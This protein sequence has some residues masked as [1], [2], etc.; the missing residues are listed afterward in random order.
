MASYIDYLSAQIDDEDRSEIIDGVRNEQLEDMLTILYAM[1]DYVIMT[2]N[3]RQTG[4]LDS[5]ELR[6]VIR[7]LYALTDRFIDIRTCCYMVVQCL[8]NLEQV[9]PQ[10]QPVIQ[11]LC[12]PGAKLPEKIRR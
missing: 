8:D 11:Q 6:T 3:Y 2:C 10:V 5:N 9:Y 1:Q 7:K 12:S 4:I